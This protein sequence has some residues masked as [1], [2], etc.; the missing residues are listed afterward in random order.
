L[1]GKKVGKSMGNRG[2]T[3][4][5]WGIVANPRGSWMGGKTRKSAPER[6]AKG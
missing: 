1:K 2:A 5:P 4:T 6:T 3:P